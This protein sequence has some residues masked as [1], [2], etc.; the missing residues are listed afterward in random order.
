ML[1]NGGSY[2]SG[3][4]QIYK[5]YIKNGDN[6]EI[7]QEGAANAFKWMPK[8][9]GTYTF[10]VEI[11]DKQTGQVAKQEKEFTITGLEK[12]RA[13]VAI[14]AHGYESGTWTNNDVK[15][16][17][18]AEKDDDSFKC[19]LEY[20]IDG[21]EWTKYSEAINF[22]KDGEYRLTVRVN[23]NNGECY[24][25]EKQY[26]IKIDKLLPKEEVV[27][28]V[29]NNESRYIGYFICVNSN[30]DNIKSIT[31]DSKTLQDGNIIVD[32][33]GKH[34]IVVEDQAGNKSMYNFTVKEL[35]DE[36]SITLDNKDELSVIE[37][38][39][40]KIS[41]FLS[42]DKC[43]EIKTQI[44]KL[45]TKVDQLNSKNPGKEDLGRQ[46]DPS[47]NED[48][49]DNSISLTFLLVILGTSLVIIKKHK[50]AC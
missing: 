48:T 3:L 7:I 1:K 2:G 16:S 35:L 39:F 40:N 18:D 33:V 46:E 25:E 29:S 32:T 5:F 26:S 4:N 49:S 13:T 12:R 8:Y 20:K 34:S 31:L 10:G 38:D 14:N 50:T 9:G 36:D 30:A 22:D 43:D 37:S 21:G 44:A 23:I 6:I 27:L 47:N 41:T 11:T 19:T 17:I 15:L 42:K 24:S 28:G 45:K